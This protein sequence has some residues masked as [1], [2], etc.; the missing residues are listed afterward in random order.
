MYSLDM[1]VEEL[2]QEGFLFDC[3]A[4]EVEYRVRT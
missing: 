2:A 4:F 1:N 3:I